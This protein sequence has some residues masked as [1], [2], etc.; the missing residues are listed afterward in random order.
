MIVHPSFISTQQLQG[1][2]FECLHQKCVRRKL[3]LL[4]FKDTHLEGL[5]IF[6][7]HT[8]ESQKY[9]NENELY[10]ASMME[11]FLCSSNFYLAHSR[12]TKVL[13]CK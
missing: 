3:Q 2:Q 10:L 8:Q 11:G 7:L 6:I 12:V 4:M 1:N 13:K 9:C 5:P